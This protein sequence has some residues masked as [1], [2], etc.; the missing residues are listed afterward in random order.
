MVIIT[1]YILIIYRLK[2][3]GNR[4]L[5]QDGQGAQRNS[6]Y[7]ME[8]R[9][10]GGAGRK[11]MQEDVVTVAKTQSLSVPSTLAPPEVSCGEIS[12]I[13]TLHR[14]K[15]EKKRKRKRQENEMTVTVGVI[16]L[17]Y[18]LCNLPVNLVLVLDPSA[19]YIPMIHIPVYILAWLSPVVSPVVYVLFN[20]SY[21][22][23]FSDTRWTIKHFCS[24]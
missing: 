2:K 22:Q 4:V 14:C 18:I 5:A 24:R 12:N 20:T 21:R 3:S 6:Q 15:T 17:S 8:T 11:E 7:V 19:E 13:E 10:T 16:F 9:I 23:A 1:C